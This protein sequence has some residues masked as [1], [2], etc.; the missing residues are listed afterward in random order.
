MENVLLVGKFS[1]KNTNFGLK[2]RHLGGGFSGKIELLSTHDNL[3]CGLPDVVQRVAAHVR[4]GDLQLLEDDGVDDDEDDERQNEEDGRVEDVEVEDVVAGRGAHL[5]QALVRHRRVA[6][7]GVDDVVLE[8]TRHVE[9]HRQHV[10]HRHLRM[11]TQSPT[12]SSDNF[13]ARQLYRQALLTARISY[14]DSVCLSVRHDPVP[15]QG[16]VRYRLRV[17]SIW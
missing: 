12:A 8:D 13:H 14:G 4:L 10:D 7:A 5:R 11:Q 1:S 6:L 15:I 3:L 9:Q 16:E 17:S 2:I